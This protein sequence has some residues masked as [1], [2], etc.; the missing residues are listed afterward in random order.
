MYLGGSDRHRRNPGNPS[1]P[2]HNHWNV[3]AG[4]C[5]ADS[6]LGFRRRTD[7]Q[8]AFLR[9]QRFGTAERDATMDQLDGAVADI[10][11]SYVQN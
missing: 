6:D 11:T 9:F 1:L 2:I 7:G 4:R 3:V 5:I 10:E 8:D